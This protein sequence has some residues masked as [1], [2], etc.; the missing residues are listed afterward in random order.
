MGGKSVNTGC[1]FPTRVGVNRRE[2]EA[3]QRWL[4]FP[5]T[6]GGEP[7]IAYL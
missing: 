5:H 1:D 4:G 7:M 6:C 3:A 2:Q